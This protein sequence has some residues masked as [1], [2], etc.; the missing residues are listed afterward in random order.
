MNFLAHAFLSYEKPEILTGNLMADVLRGKPAE[1]LPAK[2]REG[3]FIHRQIDDF[4]DHH[5][6]NSQAAEIFKKSAGRLAPVF[7]DIA[8]DYFL[9]NHAEHFPT[10][11]HLNAFAR[12]TYDS[13]H[14]HLAFTPEKFQILFRRMSD[15]DWLSGYRAEQNISRSFHS[16][17]F[18]TKLLTDTAPVYETFRREKKLLNRHFE[19]FFPELEN[20]VKNLLFSRD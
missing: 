7:L 19:R 6:E 1:T 8:Y 10:Q 9:A 14:E 2:I 18:R 11:T 16:V 20:H 3:I 4:T 12:Q 5:P 15:H 17:T 13:V